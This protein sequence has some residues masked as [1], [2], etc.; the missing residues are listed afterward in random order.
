MRKHGRLL[1]NGG[2]RE[3][4][5][6][7]RKKKAGTYKLEPVVHFPSFLYSSISIINIISINIKS[8]F[9]SME[10]KKKSPHHH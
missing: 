9:A 8:F 4:K 5:E 2:K 7:K 3:R 10:K 6:K 1:Y